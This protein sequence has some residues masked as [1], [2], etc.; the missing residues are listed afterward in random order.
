MVK[1]VKTLE[2]RVKE[3]RKEKG[4]RQDELAG[5]INVSQQTISRIENGENS[6]PADLLIHLAKFFHVSV[7]YILKLSDVRYIPE[8]RIEIEKITERNMEV[9]RLYEKLGKKNQELVYRLMEQ[10]NDSENNKNQEEYG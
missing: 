5:K 4:L 9:C 3:L 8:Y 10:L 1:G 6:L 2:N 7:D